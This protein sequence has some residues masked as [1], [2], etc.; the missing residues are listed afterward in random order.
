MRI[1]DNPEY[2][3]FRDVINNVF[4]IEKVQRQK[5]TKIVFYLKDN[6]T[7]SCE[8]PITTEEFLKI[9]RKKSS[10]E[11]AILNNSNSY[12]FINKKFVV[13]YQINP[14]TNR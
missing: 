1:N 11:V 8:T 2:N 14:T 5:M 6:T 9:Y 3:F 7:I 13:G 12:T 10:R 4:D